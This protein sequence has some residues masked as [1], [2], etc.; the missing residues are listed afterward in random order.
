MPNI[1]MYDFKEMIKKEKLDSL[2]L[3]YGNESYMIRQFKNMIIDRTMNKA[4]R[5]FNYSEFSDNNFSAQSFYDTVE[6]C[7]MMSDKR[8]VVINNVDFSAL[9]TQEYDNFKS[10]LEDIPDTTVVIIIAHKLDSTVFKTSKWKNIISICEKVGVCVETKPLKN[11]EISSLI[12]Q[13]VKKAKGQISVTTASF[14]VERLESD[15]DG[16]LSETDKLIMY[17]QG[18]EITKKNITD[19]VCSQ[20]SSMAY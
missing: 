6:M 10:V 18:N 13:R 9:S 16:I 12:V 15:I 1:S 4:D 20:I 7:P 17:A 3:L 19:V 14:L 5:G 8:C 11:N 2:Y